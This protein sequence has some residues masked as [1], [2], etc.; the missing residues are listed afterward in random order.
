MIDTSAYVQGDLPIAKRYMLWTID[1]AFLLFQSDFRQSNISRT[2]FYDNR[3][4]NVLLSRDMPHNMCVCKYHANFA[5]ILEAVSKKIPSIPSKFDQFLKLICCNVDNEVC[6]NNECDDCL[7]NVEHDIIPLKFLNEMEDTIKW[8]QWRLVQNRMVLT[9]SEASL[10]TLTFELQSQMPFFKRHCFIK[11][12]QQRYFECAKKNLKPGELILQVDFAENYRLLNQNEI[13]SAHFTY[14]Q[15]TLF[16]CVAWLYKEKMSFAIISDKLTHNKYDVYCF[17]TEI[18]SQIKRSKNVSKILIFS[19]GCNS[20]F[21]NKFILSS[22]PELVKELRI[23]E[24]EWNF[25]ATSHGKG[26]VDG[27]GAIVK[28]KVWE[29]VRTQN[30]ILNNASDFYTCA[31]NNISGIRIEYIDSQKIDNSTQSLQIRWL[32]TKN[33]KGLKSLHHFSYLNAKY[34]NVAR[35]A[36][37]QKSPV[38][39]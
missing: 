14:T 11:S 34:I 25:F 9:H 33:I 31:A 10:E 16:T 38:N 3:P 2:K 20:Q 24:F 4:K 32:K 39:I 6:M 12:S 7:L 29:I 18:V 26:A 8:T 19:D 23:N 13:Q 5:F 30:V 22:I 1:E 36:V 17:I 28:R 37:S 15:V 27:I 21:K 35:T